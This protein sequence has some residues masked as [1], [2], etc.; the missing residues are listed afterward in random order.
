MRA[1]DLTGLRFGRL[2]ALCR[3]ESS[4]SGVPWLCV[5]DCGTE[6]TTSSRHL[7]K[8]DTRS[9]GCLALENSIAMGHAN[10]PVNGRASRRAV[11]TYLSAHERVYRA[12]GKAT[13]Y[14]CSCGIPAQ[15]WAYDHADPDERNAAGRG[16]YSLDPS[17]YAA[18]CKPCHRKMD[19]KRRELSL[20]KEHPIKLH[21]A[22]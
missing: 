7:R 9:C 19:S 8:G 14:I 13:G 3:V 1:L 21:R 17:H 10:G 5:C 18:L 11:V 4:M 2:V 6:V 12:H 22:G 16:P 15:Q 20:A